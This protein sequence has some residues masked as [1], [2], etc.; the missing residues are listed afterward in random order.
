MR[1]CVVYVCV[2]VECACKSV[3]VCLCENVRVFI[4]STSYIIG[5]TRKKMVANTKGIGP[6]T[7]QRACNSTTNTCTKYLCT[8]HSAVFGPE[9]ERDGP[10]L[11][12]CS[13]EFFILI[14]I[15]AS[16]AKPH[17]DNTSGIFI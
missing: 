11:P 6:T 10:K 2:C 12:D 9:G 7:L 1:V 3:C 16:T 13:S 8:K 5:M 4:G 15:G 14:I 17:M